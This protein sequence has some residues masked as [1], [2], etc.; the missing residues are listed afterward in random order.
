[1]QKAVPFTVAVLILSL[2]AVAICQTGSGSL[3]VPLKSVSHSKVRN[4]TSVD[5]QYCMVFAIEDI[6]VPARISGQL[7]EVNVREGQTVD[8]EQ[9]LA[10][11]DDSIA[12]LQLQAAK[13]KLSSIEFRASNDSRVRVAT[14]TYRV[15][16]DEHQ[17]AKRLARTNAIPQ[18]QLRR[19]ALRED[20]ARIAVENETHEHN[21]AQKE[22]IVEKQNVAIAMA[23][24]LQYLINA[25][26]QGTV[27]KLYVSAGEWVKSGDKVMQVVR[28]DKLWVE[29]FVEA[30]QYDPYEI[31]GR[32]VT[33]TAKFANNT[34]E[35]FD[36]KVIFVGLEKSAGGRF[37][38][39][40]EIAN[41][42]AGDGSHWH[43]L[44]GSAVQMTIRLQ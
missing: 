8:K 38:V 37:V 43:L 19:A 40:A 3:N 16:A 30:D 28:M 4:E 27:K 44:P 34:V 29:G 35:T 6:D 36:G 25:P 24:T 22:V 2:H 10:K 21:L 39:R 41:R 23:Q 12:Q 33:V 1:M 20:E 17:D 14:A 42:R 18:Q 26:T 13:D 31:D 11:V 7:V 5:V 15:A 32:N 9:V